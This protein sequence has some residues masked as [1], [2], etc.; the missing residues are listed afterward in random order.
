MGLAGFLAR[1]VGPSL[2][3]T[4]CGIGGGAAPA[5]PAMP[6]GTANGPP[7]LLLRDA[8]GAIVARAILTPR[9][10]GTLVQ[11]EAIHLSPGLHGFHIHAVGKCDAPE[12]TSAGA[13]FN[14]GGNHSGDLPGLPVGSDGAGSAEFLVEGATLAGGSPNSLRGT[15]TGSSLVVHADG[16][17]GPRVACAVIGP[18]TGP[19]P[20]PTPPPPP[21]PPDPNV[22]GVPPA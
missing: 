9:G 5:T 12:F 15:Q 13:H 17:S 21:P 7:T 20:T 8:G 14:P 22:D 19:F 10:H 2:A 3:L 6:D 4:A 16:A 1:I 18:G 11:V